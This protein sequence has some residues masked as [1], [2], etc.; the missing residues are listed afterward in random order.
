MKKRNKLLKKAAKRMHER[1]V[2]D[3]PWQQRLMLYT[4]MQMAERGKGILDAVRDRVGGEPLAGHVID[5]LMNAAAGMERAAI[6]A[7]PAAFDDAM[8]AV[9]FL[10]R[11]LAYQQGKMQ[12]VSSGTVRP[13]PP[14]D[15]PATEPFDA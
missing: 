8:V 13:L 14:D 15:G 11:H 2:A 12:A 6:G 4:T 1:L 3:V 9:L 7:D 10:A 5:V